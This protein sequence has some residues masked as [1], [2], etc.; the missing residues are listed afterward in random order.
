[1][2]STENYTSSDNVKRRVITHV[3]YA[4]AHTKDLQ[5]VRTTSVELIE[6]M[7]IKKLFHGYYTSYYTEIQVCYMDKKDLVQGIGF[8]RKKKQ[9]KFQE[10]GS[11]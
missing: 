10:A 1:M 9:G 11:C 2:Y 5:L 6:R 8:D 7:L 4:I 3:R